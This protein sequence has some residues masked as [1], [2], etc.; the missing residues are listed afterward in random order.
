[1]ELILTTA[2][3]QLLVDI[4]EER[5]RSL[6]REIWHTDHYEFKLALRRN[7]QMLESILSRLHAAPLEEVRG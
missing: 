3:Q 6:L 5:H 4:L 1:M 2:E 7:E